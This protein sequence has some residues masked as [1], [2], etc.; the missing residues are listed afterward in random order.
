MTIPQTEH[1]T[2]ET[3]VVAAHG[4]SVVVSVAFGEIEI[5]GL[6]VV[7][8]LGFDEVTADELVPVT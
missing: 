1:T 2:L 4:S 6:G 7:T 5:V 8:I 3:E